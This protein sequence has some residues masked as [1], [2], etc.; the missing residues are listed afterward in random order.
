MRCILFPLLL[1]LIIRSYTQELPAEF[2]YGDSE[3]DSFIVDNFVRPDPCL[4]FGINYDAHVRFTVDTN[5][6]VLH[7]LILDIQSTGKWSDSFKPKVD[8]LKP[9]VKEE[10]LR[11]IKFSSG[12]W[13]PR[14]VD[15]KKE[16][17]TIIYYFPLRTPEYYSRMEGYRQFGIDILTMPYYIP[18]DV[19]YDNPVKYYN[20]GVKKLT[21]KKFY[22]AIKY[23]QHSVNLGNM[24]KDAFYNLGVALH[25][26]KEKDKACESWRKAL[27]L[28]DDEA[29]SL[30]EKY[31]ITKI[32][33]E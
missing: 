3:L 9:I 16:N 8:S 23:F 4:E 27:S 24:T 19:P 2:V 22:T 11:V 14:M 33:L 29:E 30:I 13:I 25:F 32:N 17:D 5:R 10:L 18:F 6:Q 21:Q 12:L 1:L 31:C 28:G 7:P 20:L 15:G 26:N